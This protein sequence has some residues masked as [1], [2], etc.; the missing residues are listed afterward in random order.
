MEAE[1]PVPDKERLQALATQLDGLFKE[2]LASKT[3][4]EERWVKDLYAYNSE[5]E[6]GV[7]AGIKQNGGSEAFLSLTRTKCNAAE[8]R[9]ND[10]ELPTEDRNWS[11][12]RTPIPKLIM[13]E[14]RTKPVMGPN[15]PMV[16]PDGKQLNVAQVLEQELKRAEDGAAA[17]QEVMDDQLSECDYNATRRLVNHFRVVYGTGI[18][19]GPVIRNRVQQRYVRNGA[20]WRI[21]YVEDLTPSCRAVN[22][23]DWFPDMRA[24]RMSEAE[25][26]IER[27]RMTKKDLMDLKKLPGFLEEQIDIVLE[28]EPAKTMSGMVDQAASQDVNAKMRGRYEVLEYTGPI[29]REDLVAAMD[30]IP[31]NEMRR[32]NGTVFWVN[33]IVI[34]A[35]ANLLDT[36]EMMYDSVPYERDDT[37]ILGFG[38]P[39][40]LRSSQSSASAAWRMILDNARASVGPVILERLGKVQPVV[41]DWR[42]LPFK[43]LAVTDPNT[44]LEDAIR[45]LETPSRLQDIFSIVEASIRFL[46]EESGLPMIAQGQQSPSVTKTAQG[47]T[48]LMNSANTVLRRMVKESDDYI[49]APFLKRL[50]QWNMQYS[51]REDAKGDFSIIP[52]GSSSLMVREQQS[53]QL[54]QLAEIAGKIPPFAERTKWAELYGKILQAMNLSSEGLVYSD[55][56]IEQ[57]KKDEP[58]QTPPEVQLAMAELQIKQAKLELERAESDHRMKTEAAELHIMSLREADDIDAEKARAMSVREQSLL[59]L[60]KSREELQ[61][62]V[63]IAEINKD[64]ATLRLATERAISESR[65][66]ADT[67]RSAMLI[68]SKHKLFNAERNLALT[69]GEGI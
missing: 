57:K 41:G 26:V 68:D 16:G 59:D 25:F 53:Q 48:L 50:Y 43:R 33:G 40:I 21:H 44:K 8:A 69:K 22:P 29:M 66:R 64:I 7:L 14:Q 23:W 6:P 42:W 19:K 11:I 37:S 36:G 30:D 18:L 62:R 3:S 39:F 15:G 61:A 67:L 54:M 4:I 65:T 60:K 2:Q 27:H 9:L 32:I 63:A 51:D 28:T 10:M 35:V 49:T 13:E 1:I 17:M 46:D 52:L 55:E 45:L 24:T 12:A 38:L 47:M 58:Q 5:Y 34:K 56:E 31:S 20:S